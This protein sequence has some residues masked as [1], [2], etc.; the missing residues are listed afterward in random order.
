MVTVY[1]DTKFTMGGAFTEFADADT[2][3]T[4]GIDTRAQKYPSFKRKSY[5]LPKSQIG[6]LKFAPTSDVEDQ[7]VDY[8]GVAQFT[9]INK[10]DVY[11]VTFMVPIDAVAAPVDAT[12]AL[13][14][15]AKQYRLM[16]DYCVK[17]VDM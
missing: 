12:L 7:A 4:P 16:T 1:S 17:Y 11:Q 9:P 14:N 2:A 3:N 8:L 6:K 13:V 15:N 5:S 10:P